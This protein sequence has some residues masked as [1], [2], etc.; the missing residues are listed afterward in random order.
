MN[1]DQLYKKIVGIPGCILEF[2]VQWGTTL[3]QLISLRGIYEP[4]NHRRHIFGFDTFDGFYN[5]DKKKDGLHLVDGDYKVYDGYINKLDYLLTL[6]EKSS[7]LSH[8]KKFSL[9]KGDASI[10]TKKWVN[11]NPQAI[12]SMAIFDMDIYKPTKDS[13]KAIIPKLVKGSVLVFDEINCPTF[14]G[15]TQAL[16]EVLGLNKL[17]LNQNPHQPNCAWAIWGD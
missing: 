12:I 14:P 2:G 6:Q 15:E 13:L 1:S 7:P 10:T 17:K 8:L 9:I 5:T 4:Y 16:D 11:E 3:S